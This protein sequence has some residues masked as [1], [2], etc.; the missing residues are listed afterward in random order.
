MF[1]K[2]LTITIETK[3]VR[4]IIQTVMLIIKHIFWP[5]KLMIILIYLFLFDK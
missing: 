5:V 1:M 3:P 4:F 2:L